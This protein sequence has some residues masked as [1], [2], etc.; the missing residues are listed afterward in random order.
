MPP[1]FLIPKNPDLTA[2]KTTRQQHRWAF[3][4]VMAQDKQAP[5]TKIKRFVK[6]FHLRGGFGWRLLGNF[7]EEY[8]H[9]WAKRKTVAKKA[10]DDAKAQIE[11]YDRQMR[12]RRIHKLQ[13]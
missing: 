13:K 9:G 11:E 3:G 7:G 5:N 10:G 1:I 2:M 6:I 8:A 4:N 12:E